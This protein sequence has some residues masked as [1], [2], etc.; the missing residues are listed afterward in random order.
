MLC[1]VYENDD[2]KCKDVSKGVW[3]NGFWTHFFIVF[4][5]AEMAVSGESFRRV[6]LKW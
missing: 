3:R 5:T 6:L 4:L 2:S 1:E